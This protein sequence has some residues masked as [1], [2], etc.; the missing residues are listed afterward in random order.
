MGDPGFIYNF[1]SGY[2]SPVIDITGKPIRID[3]AFVPSDIAPASGLIA[4]KELLPDSDA[5]LPAGVANAT[6]ANSLVS[7]LESGTFAVPSISTV[8]QWLIDTFWNLGALPQLNSV[9]TGVLSGFL[10]VDNF[11]F[12]SS[13]PT[14][15]VRA[16]TIGDPQLGNWL[17]FDFWLPSVSLNITFGN[18]I[19]YPGR[20]AAPTLFDAGPGGGLGAGTYSYAVTSLDGYGG[21]TAI[22]GVA[23]L[24]L[25]TSGHSV[26]LSWPAIGNANGGYNIYRS[27]VGES[28]ILFLLATVQNS[29]P[30]PITFTDTA[31]DSALSPNILASTTSPWIPTWWD[32][33]NPILR[34]GYL[35]SPSAP[36]RIGPTVT[37][38]GRVGVLGPLGQGTYRYAITALSGSGDETASS[39]FSVFTFNEYGHVANLSWI[40]LPG[41]DGGYNIYRCLANQAGNAVY[42]AGHIGQ[43][44]GWNGHNV[45]TIRYTDSLSDDGLVQTTVPPNGAQFPPGWTGASVGPF[46]HGRFTYSVDLEFGLTVHLDSWPNAVAAPWFNVLNASFQP[47]GYM[48]TKIDIGQIL[49]DFKSFFVTLGDFFSA[50]NW[51]PGQSPQNAI[52][53]VAGAGTS[54][55][56]LPQNP[57]TAVATAFAQ[58]EAAAAKFGF[59]KCTAAAITQDTATPLSLLM[60]HPIDPPPTA[61][62]L[63]TMVGPGQPA[64]AQYSMATSQLQATP[65]GQLGVTGSGFPSVAQMGIGW[66]DTCS[67]FVTGSDVLWGPEGQPRTWSHLPASANFQFRPYAPATLPVPLPFPPRPAAQPPAAGPYVFSVRNSDD[68]QTHP[69]TTTQYSDPV[70][71]WCAGTVNL[72]LSYQSSG[73]MNLPGPVVVGTPTVGSD[74]SFTTVVII[75]PDALPGAATLCAQVWG[76]DVFCLPITIVTR[77]TPMLRLVDSINLTTLSTPYNVYSSYAA[78]AAGEAFTPGGHVNLYIDQDHGKAIAPP[79]T[80]AADGTFVSKFTWP[81]LVPTAHTLYAVE[82]TGGKTIEASVPIFV[83]EL[84]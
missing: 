69:L 47:H 11:T 5:S 30:G 74:G 57:F 60:S 81:P 54:G 21:E 12:T 78:A 15:R 28:G 17:L 23:T 2:G 55:V 66:T 73:K 41:A 34:Y 29:A 70:T 48:R 25:E 20:P 46:D 45:P 58:T 52:Q 40:P 84:G 82:K 75:P 22:S 6:D 10:G 83:Q 3:L 19:N 50:G 1:L 42:L 36:F 68:D 32:P 26:T 37:D 27:P 53:A 59:L 80:V 8:P 62:D 65:G 64:F 79:A 16:R 43:P 38:G 24:P 4:G 35:I 51:N 56:S 39:P 7:Q 67:G 14:P 31:A 71:V 44:T 61:F 13:V 76:E 63:S 77:V 18:V 9:F 49:W 33:Y 72:T